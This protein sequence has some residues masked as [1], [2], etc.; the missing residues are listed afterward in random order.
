LY[1]FL[2][3]LSRFSSNFGFSSKPQEAAHGSRDGPSRLQLPWKGI[4][5]THPAKGK[6][7]MKMS[8]SFLGLAAVFILAVVAAAAFIR[9]P[10]PWPGWQLASCYPGCFCEAF[11]TGGVVQ[12]LSA[13]SNLFYILAGLMILGT[14]DWPDREA[15][16][17]R[18]ARRRGHIAGYGWA[19]VAIGAT[20]FFFHVSLTHIGR[21]LD[22]MGMYAFA[23]YA[24]VYSLARLRRWSDATFVVA[25]GLLLAALGVLWFAAP[26]YRRPLL[27]GVILGVIAVEAAAHWLRRPLRIRTGWL[28]A[29]LGSFLVA[30]AVN[31][32]DESGAICVPGSPWQWHAVWHFLTAASTVLL[33]VY[34]RSE[35]EQGYRGGK[36][37]QDLQ[38]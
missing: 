35:D 16:G 12:P 18:M 23:G 3:R 14:R 34:Y 15:R 6:K 27:G 38:D 26:G 11:H 29:A 5:E 9:L 20:S 8:K 33:Y 21:W 4:R 31:M 13:Y 36:N 37:R 32:S 30:Y 28:L 19:V 2:P 24:L 25:Y 22:Y 17:N 10:F 1:F 7:D